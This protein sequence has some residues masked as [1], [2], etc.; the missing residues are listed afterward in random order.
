MDY[1]NINNKFKKYKLDS[2]YESMNK[3][4]KP[5]KFKLQPSQKFLGDLF[6]SKYSPKSILIYHKIGAG[7]TCTA[8]NI[9]EKV[10]NKMKIMV[11]LS[12]SLIGNFRNELRSECPGNLYLS[13]SNRNKLETLN[14][15]SDLYK[16]IIYESDIKINKYY[17]ILSYNKFLN[18]CKNCKIKLKNHLLI[19]DE[20]Q[21]MISESGS[22]YTNLKK[23]IYSTDDSLKIVLLSATPIFD[24][25]VE[26]SLTL[27]LLKPKIQLP[28]GAYFDKMFLEKKSNNY[29]V[30]NINNFKKM[31]KGLVS[32]YRGA[33]PQAFPEERFNIVKCKMQPF[34]YSSYLASLSDE[35]SYIRGSF[36]NIDLL[37][38]PNDFFL[39]SRMISNISFPNKSIGIYGLKSFNK[40][41]L[42]LKNIKDYSI[43]FYKI[44]KKITKSNGPVFIYSNFKNTG[45]IK[46]LVLFLESKGYKNYKIFGE[47]EKRYS[48]WSGD[49]NNEIKE[50]I[51]FVFNK[52][53]NK[54]G[55]KIKIMLGTPAI[56]EGV[57]LLRVSQVH[58][59]EPYWNLSRLHQIIGR[60]IRFCSHKDLPKDDRFVDVYLYLATYPGKITIDQQIWNIAKKKRKIIKHFEKALKEMAI[61]C[62]LFYKRNVYSDEEDLNCYNED[63][64]NRYFK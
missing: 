23:Q 10:K 63:S 58:I 45:G 18:L 56:K 50:E 4:C 36:K 8:I 43:K 33:P 30:K 12:A 20:I 19:I 29:K 9:A 7:K 37:K 55:E 21:N 15:K 27:N 42:L 13:D 24:K 62:E 5:K 32:Y 17:E 60:A 39:G 11:V 25:P 57:S 52:K 16:K 28:I 2:N 44:Y 22:F 41:S 31:I 54:N 61:D 6:N 53:E 38:L 48:I 64:E 49:E 51:K 46:S 1:E 14:P 26:I 3:I 34:Q 59:L 35:K 40:N 47:G